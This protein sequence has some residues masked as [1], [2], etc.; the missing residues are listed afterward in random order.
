MKQSVRVVLAWLAAVIVAA[1]LGAFVHTQFT[2]S[3][4]ASLGAP[5][6]PAIRLQASLRDLL[7]FA[8]SFAAIMAVGYLLA[9]AATALLRR[10]WPLRRE[11]IY[12]LAGAVS[13]LTAMLA[14]LALFELHAI[15]ITRS[16]A[17]L[18]ALVACGGLGGWLFGCLLARDQKRR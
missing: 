3:S 2:L 7:G 6:T 13:V 17:G 16:P 8:P 4:L 14:M 1:I 15:A 12:A 11:P 9:F 5:V 10:Y 18:A